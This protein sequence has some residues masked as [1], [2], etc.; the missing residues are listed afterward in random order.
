MSKSDTRSSI[1][2]IPRRQT[3]VGFVALGLF[4]AALLAAREKP[5]ARIKADVSLVLVDATVKDKAGHVLDNLKREDFRLNQDGQAQAIAHFSRGELP[6]ALALVVQRNNWVGPFLGPLR[7]ATLSVLKALKP[8][9]QVALFAF[10]DD[11]ERRVD[12]TTDKNKVAEQIELRGRGEG[13]NINDA[14][15]QAA[16]YLQDAAP[17]TARR[18]IV[19][20]SDNMPAE[21]KPGVS[22]KLVLDTALEA[23]VAV[24]GLKLPYRGPFAM[25]IGD[26][27]VEH[28]LVSV[29]K[30]TGET[31]GEVIEL[32]K[33]GSLYL[34]FQ[35][36]LT[37]LKTR[38]TLGFYPTPKLEDGKFH[39]LDLQL[40]ANFGGK[41]RDYAVVAKSGYYAPS[42]RVA[43]LG[44]TG[45]IPKR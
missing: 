35:T 24:Y 36:I 43:S 7:Y 18:V 17:A 6:L 42:S 41:G 27:L 20:V 13:T 30:L 25:R 31:G 19:L 29:S 34:A 28:W 38:Y 45:D 22:H 10:D 32:E 37:R 3:L 39:K 11:V 40:A 4:G 14:I 15:Y 26:A 33:E 12:L 44:G 9:D 8:E 16:K 2:R 23:D 21:C 1:A 5:Q